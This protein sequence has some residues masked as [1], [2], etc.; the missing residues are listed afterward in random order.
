M[1]QHPTDQELSA[2]QVAVLR[3][4]DAQ[5]HGRRRVRE[6]PGRYL[7]GAQLAGAA[8]MTYGA[9]AHALLALARRDLV[10]SARREVGGLAW[11]LTTLG[12]AALAAAPAQLDL[13][14]V[15]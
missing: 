14:A 13:D 7:T 6:V 2:G 12:A 10:V 3:V 9:A 15:A 5:A 11:T 4:L 8:G 1:Q